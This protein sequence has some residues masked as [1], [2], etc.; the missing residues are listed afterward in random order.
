MLKFYIFYLQFT[1]NCAVRRHKFA[2]YRVAL[3]LYT[4]GTCLSSAFY[5]TE[6]LRLLTLLKQRDF[7]HFQDIRRRYTGSIPR[8]DNA[9]N[10]KMGPL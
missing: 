4:P 2:S 9:K 6:I 8:E 5:P 10:E 7:L 3:A 1:K